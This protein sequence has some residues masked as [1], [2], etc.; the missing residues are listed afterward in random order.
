MKIKRVTKATDLH[1]KSIILAGSLWLKFIYDHFT[2]P[3]AIVTTKAINKI[4]SSL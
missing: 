2:T 4:S 1:V 3:Q